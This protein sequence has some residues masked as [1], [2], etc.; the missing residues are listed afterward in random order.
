VRS[1]SRAVGIAGS[2]AD[3]DCSA[4][5]QLLYCARIQQ[6]IRAFEQVFADLISKGDGN[7]HAA[8]AGVA[9]RKTIH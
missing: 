2:M 1:S 5:R 3:A 7:E 4:S 6:T 9:R 8:C